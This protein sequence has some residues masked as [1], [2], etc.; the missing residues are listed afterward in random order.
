MMLFW[1]ISFVF[2]LDA[3][4]QYYNSDFTTYSQEYKDYLKKF[5]LAQIDSYEYGNTGAG[6][7]VYLFGAIWYS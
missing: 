2:P 7:Y 1:K 6:W 5:F 3:A 4:C